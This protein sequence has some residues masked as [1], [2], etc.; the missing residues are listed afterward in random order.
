MIMSKSECGGELILP[1]PQNYKE[2]IRMREIIKVIAGVVLMGMDEV[3]FLG[4][5]VHQE[6]KR[7]S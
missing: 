4:Q 7:V 6:N 5:E 1:K 2:E 3:D